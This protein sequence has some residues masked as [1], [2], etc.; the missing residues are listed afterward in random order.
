MY[1][2]RISNDIWITHEDN[3]KDKID[4]CDIYQKKAILTK[5]NLAKRNRKVGKLAT[6]WNLFIIYFVCHA[7][8]FFWHATCKFKVFVP[9]S[10]LKI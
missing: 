9:W 6:S 10:I 7:N 5:D 4:L 8:K 2:H 1:K 3:F